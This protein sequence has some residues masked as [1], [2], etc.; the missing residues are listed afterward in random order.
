MINKRR[1]AHGEKGL[2]GKEMAEAAHLIYR[3]RT[4]SIAF[5][6]SGWI[7]AIKALSALVP[8]TGAKRFDKDA[9]QVGV[10]KGS[11]RSAKASLLIIK[12]IITNSANARHDH[13]EATEKYG[14]PALEKAFDDEVAS[15]KVYIEN[16]MRTDAKNAGIKT[17][18]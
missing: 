10:A 5:I 16:K 12:A 9:V 7:P 15:M 18:H 4:R 14:A 8:S 1:A 11:V 13:T 3:V 6:K 2:Y 17:E